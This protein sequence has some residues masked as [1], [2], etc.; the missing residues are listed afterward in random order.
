M[1]YAS[2]GGGRCSKLLDVRWSMDR[3]DLWTLGPDSIFGVQVVP[4]SWKQWSA[5]DHFPCVD[6]VRFVGQRE[7]ESVRERQLFMGA[8][9][10]LSRCFIA[11][12]LIFRFRR[13]RRLG[14]TF[15]LSL[16]RPPCSFGRAGSGRIILGSSL[17]PISIDRAGYDSQVPPG[18]L[19]LDQVRLS[20]WK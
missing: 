2:K 4:T 1:R 7:R 12:A 14:P 9:L 19:A 10:Q 18:G 11:V 15:L 3:A 13:P 17:A 6:F 16:R 5:I 8:P 20:S